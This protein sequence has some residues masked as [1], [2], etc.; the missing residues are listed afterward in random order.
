MKTL[1][2]KKTIDH[3]PRKPLYACLETRT[4]LQR[5]FG[6]FTTE[7]NSDG[8]RGRRKWYKASWTVARGGGTEGTEPSCWLFAA[9]EE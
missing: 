8:G 2:M 9:R 6:V 4:K 7:E 5:V 1:K 3:S